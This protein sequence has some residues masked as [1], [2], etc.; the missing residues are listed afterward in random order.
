[1]FE[2]DLAWNTFT[3][4]KDGALSAG[5]LRLMLTLPNAKSL[6]RNSWLRLERVLLATSAQGGHG[7]LGGA[8]RGQGAGVGRAW[9]D[10]SGAGRVG[11]QEE[12]SKW[13]EDVDAETP[14]WDDDPFAHNEPSTPARYKLVALPLDPS[15]PRFPHHTFA[16]LF[17]SSFFFS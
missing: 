17:Y 1:M 6:P 8:T 12:E 13:D 7:G 3:D 9:E 15:L 16:Y 14:A 5:K 11:G 4:V 2:L 10:E